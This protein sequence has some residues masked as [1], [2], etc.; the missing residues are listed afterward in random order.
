[1][2]IFKHDEPFHTNLMCLEDYL[3]FMNKED[4]LKACK[5][6]GIY[7]SP[8]KT[9]KIIGKALADF[10]LSEPLKVLQVLPASELQIVR[11]LIDKG[12]NQYVERPMRKTFYQIQ[13]LGMVVTYED[14]PNNR[15]KMVMGDE[16]RKCLEVHID[17]VLKLKTV[18][19]VPA[20][21]LTLKVEILGTPIY[22]VLKVT[23][24]VTLGELNALIQF[25]FNWCDMHTYA[26]R[27]QKNGTYQIIMA[28]DK[29]ADLNL[30][31]GEFLDYG[32]DWEEDGD[33]WEHRL[34]V[35]AI[36]PL[37]AKEKL[38]TPVCVEAKYPDPGERSG[39][40]KKLMS[41]WEDFLEH[42]KDPSLELIND[43][44]DFFW[45][46]VGKS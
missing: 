6:L 25:L 44:L 42:E 8:N 22:R 28:Y 34:T 33:K 29:L 40:V 17:K 14:E 7:I 32:Y 4:L 16:L 3:P 41:R 13:K 27:Y 11:E 38:K 43:S 12:A 19:R 37:S 39:G 2:V 20:H 45:M 46:V 9:K 15:W 30:E 5:K 1:M 35:E 23:D 31:V 26:F 36:Q 21:E 10:L 24:L 18:K